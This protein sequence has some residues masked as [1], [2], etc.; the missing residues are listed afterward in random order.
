MN[1][2]L[3]FSFVDFYQNAVGSLTYLATASVE[4]FTLIMDTVSTQSS[5]ILCPLIPELTSG[6]FGI[7]K[8]TGGQ[9]I[10]IRILTKDYGDEGM[11]ELTVATGADLDGF[12]WVDPDS[13]EKSD[14]VRIPDLVRCLNLSYVDL[15]TGFKQAEVFSYRG[16]T[17]PMTTWYDKGGIK[18]HADL[19]RE[20]MNKLGIRMEARYE[21]GKIA[22]N[23]AKVSSG[24]MIRMDLEDKHIFND[25]TISFSDQE[26][27]VLLVFYNALEPDAR[28]PEVFRIKADGKV[29]DLIYSYNQEGEI[30]GTEAW[31]ENVLLPV[32]FEVTSTDFVPEDSKARIKVAY[33]KLREQY[34]GHEITAEANLDNLKFDL[35]DLDGLFTKDIALYLQGREIRT[36]ITRVE[37]SGG[38]TVKLKFGNARTALTEK[39]RMKGVI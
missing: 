10:L 31:E 4:S 36:R 17:I 6:D 24:E 20:A 25:Y 26:F 39:L 1:S 18:R 7:L 13:F 22:V 12:S 14:T 2:F 28:T 19:L 8:N 33:Q 5:R 35:K 37:Y 9:Q 3:A 38:S 23:L 11:M 27:N 32:K 34:L 29:T 30:I 16:E 21:E 15:F